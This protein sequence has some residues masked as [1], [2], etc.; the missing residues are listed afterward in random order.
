MKSG[1]FLLLLIVCSF[2]PS[3]SPARADD[4]VSPIETNP[5]AWLSG[6]L[7]C[8]GLI[9]QMKARYA[10]LGSFAEMPPQKK[11]ELRQ[12]LDVVCSEKYAHCKF[13]GCARLLKQQTHNQQVPDKPVVGKSEAPSQALAGKEPALSSTKG[14]VGDKPA[15]EELAQQQVAL[16]RASQ[17][18]QRLVSAHKQE[19]Q[20]E[21][22]RATKL[23]MSKRLDWERIQ[24]AAELELRKRSLE[25]RPEPA[26]SVSSA[27]QRSYSAPR[28]RVDVSSGH[29]DRDERSDRDS[30]SAPAAPPPPAF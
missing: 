30:A 24:M 7:S 23:E 11:E 25:H 17:E 19:L 28:F 4:T 13:A 12:V 10:P 27:P 14:E 21:I 6:D 16:D 9:D 26:D 18:L 20:R 5:L 22:A 29:N 15:D 1:C 2:L 3:S 8:D